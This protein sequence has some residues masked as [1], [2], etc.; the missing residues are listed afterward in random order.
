MSQLW[1]PLVVHFPIGLWITSGLFDLL[2]LW[3]GEA[4][5]ARAARALIGLGLLGALVAAGTGFLD[6]GRFSPEELGPAFLGRHRTHQAVSVAA[7]IVYA[8]SFALRLR[9]TPGRGAVALLALAGA[10]LIGWTGWLGGEL[11]MGM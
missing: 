3:R 6:L 9:R 2:Y 10:A 1:H 5:H 7:T 11:R 4:F 8:A